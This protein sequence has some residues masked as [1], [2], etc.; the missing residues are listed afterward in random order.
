MVI[1]G[2]SIISG[3]RNM[4]FCTLSAEVQ[5]NAPECEIVHFNMNKVQKL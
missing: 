1:G 3:A 4:R 2:N 5:Q